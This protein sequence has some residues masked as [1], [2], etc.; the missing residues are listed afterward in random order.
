MTGDGPDSAKLKVDEPPEP[1]HVEDA[2]EK[3][4][5]CTV[6]VKVN[7]DM[8]AQFV[9]ISEAENDSAAVDTPPTGLKATRAT[10]ALVT[11]KY[12]AKQEIAHDPEAEDTYGPN[13]IFV[14]GKLLMPKTLL[15]L[16]VILFV[17]W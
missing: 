14:I 13:A 3:V 2:P 8:N 12:D 15:K 4:R 17:A 6:E 5:V 11:L 10:S 16:T 7:P 9:G 1:P